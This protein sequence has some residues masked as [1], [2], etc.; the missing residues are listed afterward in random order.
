MKL[1]SGA[2]KYRKRNTNGLKQG[3]VS[4]AVFSFIT[5]H[6]WS[7]VLPTPAATPAVLVAPTPHNRPSKMTQISTRGKCAPRH[8]TTPSI[9]AALTTIHCNKALHR[10]SPPLECQ[11]ADIL[12]LKEQHFMPTTVLT[13]SHSLPT[14]I[15]FVAPTTCVWPPPNVFL[16]CHNPNPTLPNYPPSYRLL[17]DTPINT[18]ITHPPIEPPTSADPPMT[19]ISIPH[20]H[21]AHVTN[22][23]ETSPN[24]GP[25]KRVSAHWSITCSTN[26]Q[27]H[28]QDKLQVPAFQ[29]QQH[30][31]RIIYLNE[32]AN[33]TF[34][35]TSLLNLSLNQATAPRPSHLHV[36]PLTTQPMMSVING[37]HSLSHLRMLHD[38]MTSAIE[39]PL[40]E[41]HWFQQLKPTALTILRLTLRYLKAYFAI[42]EVYLVQN[43]D[44]G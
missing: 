28:A 34:W 2:L 39:C 36:S 40:I 14:T 7:F 42:A 3:L 11:S 22:L 31:P 33:N 29:Q 27:L 13:H 20:I 30:S 10:H 37:D 44:P 16:R 26:D 23:E 19:T 18:E 24:I 5:L 25:C 1:C 32:K 21:I 38:P 35:Q 4:C 41:K 6:W 43:V 17:H 15:L 9:N 12:I 8:D